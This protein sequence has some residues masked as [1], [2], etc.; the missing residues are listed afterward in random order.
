MDRV[1][2]IR[3][4][5]QVDVLDLAGRIIANPS[6]AMCSE[7]GKLALAYAVE[8]FWSLALAG[9][10]LARL[11]RR[12]KRIVEARGE[13]WPGIDAY[14]AIERRMDALAL[15]IAAKMAAITPQPNTNEQEQ[16]DGEG[17]G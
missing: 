8:A 3:A 2:L 6:R 5:D 14:D 1:D 9:D 7:A 16:T 11:H 13:P 17:Q 4:A 10:E 12:R 15:E